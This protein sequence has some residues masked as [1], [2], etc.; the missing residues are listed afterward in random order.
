[1]VTHTFDKIEQ[2]IR[3]GDLTA[4]DSQALSKAIHD[5]YRLHQGAKREHSALEAPMLLR[6]RALGESLTSSDPIVRASLAFNRWPRDIW[7][8]DGAEI[9]EHD[10]ILRL[11]RTERLQLVWQQSGFEGVLSVVDASEATWE[12]GRL[13]SDFAVD[14]IVPSEIENALSTPPTKLRQFTLGYI[15]GMLQSRGAE[16]FNKL[17]GSLTSHRAKGASLLALPFKPETWDRLEG[18]NSD[19][20]WTYWGDHHWFPT[21]GDGAASDRACREFLRCKNFFAAL[22][23]YAGKVT[24]GVSMSPELGV[25]VLDAYFDSCRETS[26]SPFSRELSGY[27]MGIVLGHLQSSTDANQDDVKRIEWLLLPGMHAESVSPALLLRSLASSPNDFASAVEL[28]H[29]PPP[30]VTDAEAASTRA[31]ILLDFMQT[32]P[33]LNNSNQTPSISLNDWITAARSLAVELSIVDEVD[34]RIGKLFAYA[35]E[36][37]DGTWPCSDV[38]RVMEQVGTQRLFAGFY[39]GTRGKRGFTWLSPTDGGEQERDLASQ[40]GRWAKLC[41]IRHPKVA[42]VLAALETTYLNEAAREDA[43]ISDW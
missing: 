30:E 16:W 26:T 14:A 25:S 2:L 27:E 8:I 7:E 22:H 38:Q 41:A 37:D 9:S 17:F 36:N 24:D 33:G 5:A 31:R 29:R 43:D 19:G 1:M 3:R 20:R 15:E 28:E 6:L 39:F 18:L 10:S 21:S 11:V 42:N 4:D 13:F 23:L 35:I 40:F 12:M 34:Y 32:V